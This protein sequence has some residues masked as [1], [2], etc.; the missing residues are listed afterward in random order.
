MVCF[1]QKKVVYKIYFIIEK[2]KNVCIISMSKP[3][4][5]QRSVIVDENKNE[6]IVNNLKTKGRIMIVEDDKSLL[7]MIAYLLKKESYE[8]TAVANGEEALERISRDIPDILLL[9]LDLP[10]IDG[11][12]VCRRLKQNEKTVG[13]I[14]IMLTDKS[15]EDEIA[16][17]LRTFADD[18][19]PKP[20]SVQVLLARLESIMRRNKKMKKSKPNRIKIK[21][22]VIDN[23]AREVF[24]D[25]FKIELRSSEFDALAFLASR[26]GRIL[27]RGQIIAAIRGV[28]DYSVS[29]R[30]I[31]NNIFWLR[32]KLGKHGKMIVTVPGH[33]YKL[34]N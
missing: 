34:V 4:C 9:D 33:G 11:Y 18:Y 1:V 2:L 25:G 29:E 8:V 6:K 23:D 12:E 27:S 3:L 19:V 24:V 20:F 15:S 30:V 17:G 28:G 7:N 13:I 21:N 26:P 5:C 14:I 32:K 16:E 22:I 31:D 10:G